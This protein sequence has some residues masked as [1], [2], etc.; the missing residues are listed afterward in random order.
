M[1]KAYAEI[2]ARI[3]EQMAELGS[4]W[5]KQWSAASWPQ[6]GVS[7]RHYSGINVILL[8]LTAWDRGY[9]SGRWITFRQAKA[10]GGHVR[11]G[12]RGTKVIYVGKHKVEDQNTGDEREIVFAKSYAVFNLEQ[13]DGLEDLR[14]VPQTSIDFAPF[15]PAEDVLDNCG[16]RI[17]YQGG[18]A[19]Y[20]PSRD[21]VVLPPRGTFHSSEGF[22]SVAFHEL[23]HWTGHAT[24]LDRD[25]AMAARFRSRE[26]AFEELVAELTAAFLCQRT[27]VSI[28]PREDHAKYL[29]GWIKLLDD[30]PS[31]IVRAASLAGKA[32]D[33]IIDQADQAAIAEAA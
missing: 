11:K 8:S 19:F 7:E 9:K 17:E 15:G 22:Y 5:T 29:N 10:A 13:C 28:E 33:F 23:G 26:Y 14:E 30:E 12:E 2:T 3:R 25:K 4:D 20:A 24:R 1:S 32:A 27:G 6:N 21:I 31:A 16:A 18:Q